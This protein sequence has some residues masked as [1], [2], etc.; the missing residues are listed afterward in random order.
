M[1]MSDKHTNMLESL[2]IEGFGCVNIKP[3][4]IESFFNS[5]RPIKQC[6]QIYIVLHVLHYQ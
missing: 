6:V 4:F 5:D 1:M 2:N 3:Y